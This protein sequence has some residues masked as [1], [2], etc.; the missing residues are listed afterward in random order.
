MSYWN[1]SLKSKIITTTLVYHGVRNARYNIFERESKVVRPRGC[2]HSLIPRREFAVTRFGHSFCFSQLVLIIYGWAGWQC[3]R[4]RL[5]A[6]LHGSL[7]GS[8]LDLCA[9]GSRRVSPPG[10]LFYRSR[11]VSP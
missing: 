6:L 11:K 5:R 8:L 3:Y 9:N 1:T 2:G 10:Y 4:S 7:A